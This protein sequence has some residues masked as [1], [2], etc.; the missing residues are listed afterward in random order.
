[1]H[2]SEDSINHFGTFITKSASNGFRI[3][4]NCENV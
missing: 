2:A 3:T 1:M 4:T